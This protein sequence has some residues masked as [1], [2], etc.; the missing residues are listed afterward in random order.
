[1]KAQIEEF[2]RNNFPESADHSQAEATHEQAA[3]ALSDQPSTNHDLI[4]ASTTPA[5]SPALT[6]ETEP[7][8]A[9]STQQPADTSNPD[10]STMAVHPTPD[11]TSG[12]NTESVSPQPNATAHDAATNTSAQPVSEN[13]PT[14]PA[15]AQPAPTPTPSATSGVSAVEVP[16]PAGHDQP[17]P[18]VVHATPPKPPAVPEYDDLSASGRA[19][20]PPKKVI[21]PLPQAPQP[22]LATL[23]AIEESKAPPPA[24]TPTIVDTTAKAAAP[25][26]AVTASQAIPTPMSVAPAPQD[27]DT[28][29]QLQPNTVIA[30]HPGVQEEPR[31]LDD[32]DPN[33]IAL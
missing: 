21:R 29:L 6:T 2:M 3:P 23:V 31:D 4:D 22:D 13:E 32:F 18:E 12:S 9:E 25:T 27:D 7:A 19:K 20:M 10:S 28:P 33:S 8:P 11:E 26:V 15:A 30:P 16:P 1:M 14:P 5:G 17:A 24:P